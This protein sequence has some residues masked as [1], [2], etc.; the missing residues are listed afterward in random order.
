VVSAVA[1]SID[2]ARTVKDRLVRERGDHPAVNGVG[3][4]R[5]GEGWAVK[6]NLAR[7]APDLDL[8]GEI[9]G[10]PVRT[11]VVGPVTAR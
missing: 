8:P 1:A 2:Q 11:E 4:A 6:V 7:A 10:V 5:D 9:E 3:L